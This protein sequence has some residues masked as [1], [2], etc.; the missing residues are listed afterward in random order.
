MFAINEFGLYFGVAGFSDTSAK[1]V[2]LIGGG[3][4]VKKLGKMPSLVSWLDA[5][6]DQT[7]IYFII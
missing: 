6:P 3:L 4:D 5:K 2:V 7:L 1:G